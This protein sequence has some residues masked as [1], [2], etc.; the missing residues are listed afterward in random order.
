MARHIRKGDLVV[1]TTGA[2]RGRQGKVLIMMPK[3]GMV[4]VEGVNVRKK[5]IKPSQQNPQ[6]GIVEKEMPIHAS[7]VSPAADGKPSRVRFEIKPDGSKIRVAVRSG[8]Q[9][10]RELRG[11]KK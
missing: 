2:A 8:H 4:I 11:P 1:V 6:G 10:G 9:I 5:H 7:N 3:R